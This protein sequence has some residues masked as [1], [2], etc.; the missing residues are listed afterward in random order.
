M[1]L[2]DRSREEE[3]LVAPET[4]LVTQ[5]QC[6]TGKIISE[7]YVRGRQPLDRQFEG[8]VHARR[9]SLCILRERASRQV[10]VQPRRHR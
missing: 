5:I 1:E 3:S 6:Q 7:M 10:P 2:Q 9:L 4:C 8:S